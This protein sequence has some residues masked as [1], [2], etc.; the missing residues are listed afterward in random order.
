MTVRTFGRKVGGDDEMARRVEDF[1]ACERAR[2]AEAGR[3]AAF[4]AA[5]GRAPPIRHAAPV[6]EK[7]T[8]MAYL[9]WFGLGTLGAHRFYL[10]YAQTA[11]VQASLWFVGWLLVAGTFFVGLLPVA[12]A[13]IWV[14]ADAF[15][16]PDLTRRANE[17]IRRADVAE[18]FA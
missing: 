18:A 13:T 3:E 9:F 5:S 14:I 4:A 8:A 10:G 6:R 1:L 16:I 15:L 7:S 2:K 12:A 17:R 11:I